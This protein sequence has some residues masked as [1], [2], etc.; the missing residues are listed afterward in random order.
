MSRWKL[1]GFLC[2]LVESPFPRSSLILWNPM[3]KRFWDSF[4][5]GLEPLILK[6]CS[7]P[8][9]E[10]LLTKRFKLWAQLAEHQNMYMYCIAF[11][12]IH[13]MDCLFIVYCPMPYDRLYIDCIL[14]AFRHSPPP[15]ELGPLT[16]PPPNRRPRGPPRLGPND[17][18]SL[19]WGGGGMSK[20]NQ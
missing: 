17:G 9:S 2:W 6:K 13:H 19:T 7:V 5:L 20:D 16:P 18:C 11:T 3:W 12:N 14:I 10:I 4:A 15:H 8:F 1:L